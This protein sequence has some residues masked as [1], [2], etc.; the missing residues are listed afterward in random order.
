MWVFHSKIYDYRFFVCCL[1]CV[2]STQV[3]TE[4]NRIMNVRFIMT[5][6]EKN[7]ISNGVGIMIFVKGFFIY[8]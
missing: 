4:R 2:L 7:V 3:I 8:L 1:W 5:L 6:D